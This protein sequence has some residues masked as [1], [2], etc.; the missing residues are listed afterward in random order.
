MQLTI[1]HRGVWIPWTE[2]N[3][4]MRTAL[5]AALTDRVKSEGGDPAAAI[6]VA[7]SLGGSPFGLGSGRTVTP[8]SRKTNLPR[9]LVF[10]DYPT[11]KEMEMA[12]DR[13][14]GGIL[15]VLE[16]PP[17][18]TRLPL[19]GWAAA[20]GAVDAL[21]GTLTH[22]VPDE[23]G[24]LFRRLVRY[25]NNGYGDQRANFFV[26]ELVPQI[27]DGIR[28]AGY[29]NDFIASYLLAYGLSADNEKRLRKLID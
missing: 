16:G 19:A 20:V 6:R 27:A 17:G 26:R 5:E 25:G 1:D 28:A 2:S 24:S 21:T 23:V 29:T 18:A 11:I 15:A 9:G 12:V 3:P 10:V 8:K 7:E 14:R 22:A 13:A 4:S